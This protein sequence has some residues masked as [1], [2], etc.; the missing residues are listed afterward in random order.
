[1]N[2]VNHI[3][4]KKRNNRSLTK[5][6]QAK[7]QAALAVA[8]LTLLITALPTTAVVDLVKPIGG[9]LTSGNPHTLEY[10]LAL[11]EATSCT[12]NLDGTP[13]TETA[14]ENNA[15]N[16]FTV[17]DLADGKHTWNVTCTN[18]TTQEHS[19]TETFTTD[20]TPPTIEQNTPLNNATVSAANFTFTPADNYSTTL[21]C[22][23]R[24]DETLRQ[25]DITAPN[26]K[27]YTTTFPTLQPGNHT[28]RV[29]CTDQA[30]NTATTPPASFMYT[31]PP[32]EKPFTLTI[33]KN[34]V[35][36]GEPLLLT[37]TAPDASTVTLDT[38]PDKTGFVQCYP[39]ITVQEQTYPAQETIPYTKKEGAYFIEGLLTTPQGDTKLATITYTVQNTITVTARAKNDPRVN[40]QTNLEAEAT[41]GIGDYTFTWRFPDNTLKEGREVQATFTTPGY[42]NITVNATDEEG[43]SKTTTLSLNVVAT[44]DV[45]FI[46]KDK[47]TGQPINDAT[48]SVDDQE[49]RTGT[50]GRATLS[51]PSGLQ[52][53]G[54]LKDGYRYHSEEILVDKSG[55]ITVELEPRKEARVTALSPAQD[56]QTSQLEA[57]SFL[58]SGSF[59]MTCTLWAAPNGSAWLEAG[60]NITITNEGNH[61]L[62]FNPAPGTWQWKIECT[63]AEGNL[64]TT[65]PRTVTLTAQ[66]EELPPTKQETQTASTKEYTLQPTTQDTEI[67]D[68]IFRFEQALSSLHALSGNARQAAEAM[69]LER[70]IKDAIKIMQRAK[71]D[72]NDIKYRRDLT[73]QEQEAKRAEFRDAIARAYRETPVQIKYISSKKFSTYPKQEELKELVSKAIELQEK[74]KNNYQSS[75]TNADEEEQETKRNLAAKQEALL[76]HQQSFTFATSLYHVELGFTDGSF[77]TATIVRHDFSYD[78]TTEESTVLLFIPKS[79]AKSAQDLDANEEFTTLQDDPVI[80]IGTPQTFSYLLDGTVEKD[81]IADIKPIIYKEPTSTELNKVTG[82]ALLPRGTLTPSGFLTLLIVAIL[83]YLFYIYNGFELAKDAI[84][85]VT[86]RGDVH[87]LRVLL[88]DAHDYLDSNDVQNAQAIYDELQAKYAAL[89]PSVQDEL[90]SD[91]ETLGYAINKAHFIA[92]TEVIRQNLKQGNVGEAENVY[93]HLQGTFSLL[94]EEDRRALYPTVVALAKRIAQQTQSRT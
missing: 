55:T 42:H 89:P 14:L 47:E 92:L 61:S 81:A 88:N 65:A 10:Y 13:T 69:N 74:Q 58:A 91:L 84:G 26:E 50:D 33:A 18:G 24:I 29:T 36:L 48:V 12:L 77:R 79:V 27:P 37:I 46:V 23:V 19:T 35:D 49:Q 2:H 68:K 43:N 6:K 11:P 44:Y 31:P 34:V 7:L 51:L 75:Y 72:I 3:I 67:S 21:I 56:E 54:V 9:Q 70:R 40:K 76:S 16:T 59:P 87:Y 22:E 41:G 57:V 52:D 25:K 1:M 63:D 39:T 45:T 66:E 62:P 80:A 64:L 5:T 17:P 86:K 94:S 71:R 32:Q 85:A 8:A 28:W 83:I 82:F 73:P 38:C 53:L 78:N 4:T 90:F 30:N 60:A 20:N 15:F 93:K